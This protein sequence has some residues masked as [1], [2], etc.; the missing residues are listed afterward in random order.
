MKSIR[1]EP[2]IGRS[3]DAQFHMLLQEFHESA[4]SCLHLMI[5]SF[6]CWAISLT[7][8]NWLTQKQHSTFSKRHIPPF[9][10]VNRSNPLLFHNS[11]AANVSTWSYRVTRE[12][13]MADL[14]ARFICSTLPDSFL[15]N[16]P[17][18]LQQILSAQEET[19]DTLRESEKIVYFTPMLA[20]QSHLQRLSPEPWCWP[21]F[22]LG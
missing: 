10:A 15:A 14:R 19:R 13:A 18:M 12:F 2:A 6:S 5:R 3:Q 4:N 9:S 11:T 7:I 21:S 1:R 20:Q 22:M 16:A 17:K 8:P